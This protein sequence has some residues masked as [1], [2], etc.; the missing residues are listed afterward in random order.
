MNYNLIKFDCNY[1]EYSESQYLNLKL[2]K[3]NLILNV[4]DKEKLFPD[5]GNVSVLCSKA[6]DVLHS[7]RKYFHGLLSLR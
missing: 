2:N 6:H 3:E 7:I 1:H 4:S 5:N